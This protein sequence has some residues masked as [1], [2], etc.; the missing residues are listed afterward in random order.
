MPIVVPMRRK[1]SSPV[2]ALR[3]CDDDG[4]GL[5][6]SCGVSR[7]RREKKGRARGLEGCVGEVD[8]CVVWCESAFWVGVFQVGV[9]TGAEERSSQS[10]VSIE[11]GTT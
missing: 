2:H 7:G 6:F 11:I 9:G 10:R 3:E 4:G 8:V 5:F 1:P